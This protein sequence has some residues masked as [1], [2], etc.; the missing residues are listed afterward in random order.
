MEGGGVEVTQIMGLWPGGSFRGLGMVERLGDLLEYFELKIF[1]RLYRMTGDK[2]FIPIFTV[3]GIR[4]HI[5]W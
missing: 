4:E 2:K 5:F 3:S 1:E